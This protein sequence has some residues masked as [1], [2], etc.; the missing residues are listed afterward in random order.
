MEDQV[1][2]MANTDLY[3]HGFDLND[4]NYTGGLFDDAY[5]IAGPLQSDRILLNIKSSNK[6]IDTLV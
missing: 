1:G 4:E 3:K 6:E 5:D 2:M